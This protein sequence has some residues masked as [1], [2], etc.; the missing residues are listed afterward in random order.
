[1]ANSIRK[2]LERICQRLEEELAEKEELD[3]QFR[4]EIVGMLAWGQDLGYV[5]GVLNECAK[6]VCGVELK[7]LTINEV[8][9]WPQFVAVSTIYGNG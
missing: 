6:Q 8:K 4:E 1:V 3:R 7:P 5:N 2:Q 9:S